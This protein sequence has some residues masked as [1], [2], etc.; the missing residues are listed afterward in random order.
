VRGA[1]KTLVRER[2]LGEVLLEE[3]QITDDQLSSALEEQAATGGILSEILVSS[4]FVTEWDLAK[5][6]VTRLQLPFIYTTQY[7]IPREAI[8][9]LPHT[10]LHQ[11]RLVPLDVFGTVFAIAS[12]GNISQEILGEIEL[13]TGH[14]V[15]LY[16]ALASDIQETLREKFPLEKVTD[17]LSEKFD[18]LFQSS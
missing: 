13:S 4:G 16:I 9:L 7:D 5:C 17:E 1:R 6:L 15:S 14:E 8:D 18:Q 11:H 3:R 12:A 10:F 2:K